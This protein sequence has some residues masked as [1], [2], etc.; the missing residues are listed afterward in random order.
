MENKYVLDKY[1]KDYHNL[2]GKA[3]A[4]AK[5]A[6]GDFLIP[7]WFAVSADA[8]FHS[9]NDH[10]KGYYDNYELEK[11]VKSI[12]DINI[13]AEVIEQID[14]HLQHFS[15]D[16]YFAVR[17]SAHGEDGSKNSFA[18]QLESY[19]FI[20]KKD[21]LEN[22]I[23]VWKSG[24]SNR[25]LIYRQENKLEGMPSVP[26]VLV[27]KMVNAQTAGVAFSVNPVN[28]DTKTRVV[29]AVFGLGSALVDG[30]ASADTYHVDVNNNITFKEI[31]T[32]DIYH[33]GSSNGVSI[34]EVDEQ[35]K[36]KQVLDDKKVLEIANLA[37]RLSVFLGQYQ[38]IEWAYEEDK[39]YLLQSRPITSLGKTEDKNGVLNLWD[40]SNIAES[41]GGITTPLT[42]SFIRRAYEEVYRQM[43]ILFSVPNKMIEQN[44]LTFKRMLG[45]INGRV[46]YNLLSW[47]RVL[48][49]LPGY[50]LNR[51]FMEQMMGVKKELPAEF[52]QEI[53]KPSSKEKVIDG[54]NFITSILGLLRSYFTLEK[55]IKKFYKRLDEVLAP[56]DLE[57]MSLDEL[58]SYY[59][60]LQS[61]LLTK[62]DAPLVNDFFAMIAYGLL[63][64]LS[65]KWCK[66][67]DTSLHNDLLCGEG[68][69]IS[70]QPAKLVKNMA[71]IIKENDTLINV[72]SESDLIYINSEINKT[73]KF[74][75]QIAIYIDKF[76]DR[77]LD[78][79]KL[80]SK[81]LYEDPI[82]LYRSIGSFAKRYKE[83]NIQKEISEE[84]LRKSAEEK[85]SNI[86]KYNP[87]KKYIF[88][89]VLKST[90]RLVKNRENL[91]FERTR[92]F[93]R[94]RRIYLE[95]GSRLTSFGTIEDKKDIF[96]LEIQEILGFVDGT[97]TTK[98][99][100]D[101]VKIRK[102]EFESFKINIPDDRF[103]TRG[104]V[105]IGN[106]F[107]DREETKVNINENSMKGLGCCPGIVTGKIKVIKNPQDAKL[108]QGEILVAE[109]TDPGWIMLFPAAS[110]ILVERGSLLSHSAIVSREMGIPAIVS[111]TG[112]T[113]WLKDGDYVTFDGSTGIVTKLEGDGFN[114][115]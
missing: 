110:G 5:L 23:K 107:K 30:E 82:T 74:K 70:S 88:N 22:I 103:E 66:G 78:E 43:C 29:S 6:L 59:N 56:T 109:R 76:G 51:R 112:I 13:K 16:T 95:V 92:L 47:Y 49:I 85:V 108:N 96:Y 9:L 15:D 65:E 41:Y 102:E 37:S 33:K 57:N 44:E 99:L 28:E 89:K 38:D 24:F 60:K 101:I 55:R 83:G 111:L 106:R 93:G 14:N 26:I 48:S 21:I 94:V 7:E 61:K 115:E 91:R 80:E 67:K 53:K 3:G 104:A 72:L 50:A 68:G 35:N 11:F 40:N 19:L 79:L 86:L 8:F 27:Q 1:T 10:Q 2:G 62:W 87:I 97:G 54:Y 52:L 90:R 113:Q 58:T 77:C 45:L 12:E 32:K 46:F 75:E 81:T 18:G 100:K 84:E 17:S 31:A 36:N 39:L 20:S 69:I 71:E 98:S 64:A 63:R 4:L 25:V 105:N 114:E 73:P 34:L 42:F